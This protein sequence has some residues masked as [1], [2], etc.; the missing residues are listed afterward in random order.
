M[1]QKVQAMTL[2]TVKTKIPKPTCCDAIQKYPAV[3]AELTGDWADCKSTDEC[4][5]RWHANIYWSGGRTPGYEDTTW[6]M[7]EPTCCPFCGARLPRLQRMKTPPEPLES[8]TDGGYYCDTC[9]ERCR[10]VCRC[11]PAISAFEVVYEKE[12]HQ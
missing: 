11:H 8:V 10:L 12:V 5:A 3:V 9:K 7:P 4:G 2:S 6:D 1:A